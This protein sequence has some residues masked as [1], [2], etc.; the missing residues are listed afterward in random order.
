MGQGVTREDIENEASAI[1]K[2][3]RGG[4]H[5]VISVLRHDW[6]DSSCYFI[7]M[8]LC[9]MNL[10]SFI[11]QELDWS[12][13]SCPVH[14]KYL[15][16]PHPPVWWRTVECIGVMFQLASGLEYIHSRGHVHRDLKPHNGTPVQLGANSQ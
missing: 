4:H 12:P 11:Y 16:D 3:G 1:D 8:E 9:D 5:N 14:P 6:L 15:S 13:Y 2:L 7:D 10:D